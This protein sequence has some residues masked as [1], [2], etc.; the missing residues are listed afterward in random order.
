M[1]ELH[2]TIFGV[3]IVIVLIVGGYYILKSVD[4]NHGYF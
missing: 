3:G 4:D 1:S 2:W